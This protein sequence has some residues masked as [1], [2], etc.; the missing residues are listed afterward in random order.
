MLQVQEAAMALL[1]LRPMLLCQHSKLCVPMDPP[2]LA[3][4]LR[5]MLLSQSWGSCERY[6]HMEE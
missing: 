1:S 6:Y 3:L 2:T 5:C 4:S